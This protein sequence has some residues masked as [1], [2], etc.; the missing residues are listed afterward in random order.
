[1]ETFSNMLRRNTPTLDADRDAYEKAQVWTLF[2]HWWT[3]IISKLKS[4]IIVFT[5]LLICAKI[6]FLLLKYNAP[7]Y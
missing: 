1:M 4:Q 3:F 6:L 5:L 2:I 7:H